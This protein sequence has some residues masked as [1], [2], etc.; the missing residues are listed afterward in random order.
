MKKLLITV[1]LIACVASIGLATRFLIMPLLAEML[2]KDDYKALM[3]KCDNVMQTH[4]IA[5]NRFRSDKTEDSVRQLRA[6]EVGLLNCHD[7]DKLRKKLIRWG[8]TD[9]DL[10]SFGIEAIEENATDVRTFVK[11]HEI[12]Y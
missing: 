4:L 12:K 10:S 1:N 6:A 11:T 9:N 2:Y 3:F 8:L 5:K 7:Y